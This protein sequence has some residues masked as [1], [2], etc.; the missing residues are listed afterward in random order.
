[1][2]VPDRVA[3]NKISQRRARETLMYPLVNGMTLGRVEDIP[4]LPQPRCV[5]KVEGSVEVRG[6]RSGKSAVGSE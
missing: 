1:M 2:N 3:A 4:L 6:G 5:K